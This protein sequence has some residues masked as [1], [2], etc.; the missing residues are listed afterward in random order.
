MKTVCEIVYFGRGVHVVF[1]DAN[2]FATRG[3]GVCRVFVLAFCICKTNGGGENVAR[4]T[5]GVSFLNSCFLSCLLDETEW[6]SI[7]ERRKTAGKTDVF[8]LQ[9]KD[10]L[11]FCCHFLG[12]SVE[13]R[14]SS[15]DWWRREIFTRL[16][17]RAIWGAMRPSPFKWFKSQLSA[18]MRKGCCPQQEIEGRS[19]EDRSTEG[20]TEGAWRRMRVDPCSAQPNIWASCQANHFGKGQIFSIPKCKPAPSW[21]RRLEGSA[22]SICGDLCVLGCRASGE[23]LLSTAFL[24]RRSICSDGLCSSVL[25]LWD[26]WLNSCKPSCSCLWA[27]AGWPAMA[28]NSL[29]ARSLQEGSESNQP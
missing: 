23:V 28:S 8:C 21:N 29:F 25:Y 22:V 24:S 19:R 18:E 3:V 12:F 26:T 14:P 13:V 16:C 5:L 15:R 20:S 11:D 4:E 17:P 10:D 6:V 9:E 1:W 27:H 7:I 2:N